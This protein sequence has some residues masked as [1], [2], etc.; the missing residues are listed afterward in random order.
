M[1]R[2]E[3]QLA[4]LQAKNPEKSPV[5]TML[6]RS[7][8]KR[9]DK[10]AAIQSYIKAVSAGSDSAEPFA[11]LCSIYMEQKKFP[12]ASDF[13]EK[14]LKKF[15][16]DQSLLRASARLA[17]ALDDRKKAAELYGKTNKTELTQRELNDYASVLRAGGENRKAREIYIYSG[18]K[19]VDSS[20]FEKAMEVEPDPIEKNSIINTALGVFE[21][22][23]KKISSMMMIL[24]KDLV[25][26]GRKDMASEKLK[27]ISPELLDQNDS[28]LFLRLTLE[29]SSDIIIK[30][31]VETVIA[32]RKDNYHLLRSIQDLLVNGGKSTLSA[33][34]FSGIWAKDHENPTFEYLYARSLDPMESAIEYYNSAISRNPSFGDA[35]LDL[36]KCLIAHRRYRDAEAAL[37]RAV[38]LNPSSHEANMNLFLSR[39]YES[40]SLDAI[41]T[42]HRFLESAKASNIAQTLLKYAQQIADPSYSDSLVSELEAAGDKQARYWRIRHDLV[43]SKDPA[44]HFSEY[45]P[46][47]ARELYIAFLMGRGKLKDVLLLPTPPD[48]FPEFWKVFIMWRGESDGWEGLVA[49][50]QEKNKSNGSLD[51]LSQLMLG[52]L[53]PEEARKQIYRVSQDWEPLFYLVLAERYRKMGQK[54]RSKVCYAKALGDSPGVY[55]KAIQIFENN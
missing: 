27:M 46:P 9:G 23:E 22:D 33:E 40:R 7:Q 35:L 3:F 17:M 36:G 5:Y 12:E 43:Y 14:G 24:V 2:A 42:Y 50:L 41:K 44:R 25:K 38:K 20:S 51:V 39:F 1:E 49:T 31:R 53:D 19:F 37:E 6:A 28:L 16:E 13:S 15:P 21:K 8:F 32:A 55:S 30:D 4:E 54:I 47:E 10:D 34:I 48:K 11:Q 29:S 45:Y 52:K 26:S 18:K